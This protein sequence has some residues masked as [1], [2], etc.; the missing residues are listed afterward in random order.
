M[1]EAF[2][3]NITSVA[4]KNKPIQSISVFAIYRPSGL[5]FEFLSKFSFLIQNLVVSLDKALL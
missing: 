3:T 1:F 2:Y 4:T 5:Y